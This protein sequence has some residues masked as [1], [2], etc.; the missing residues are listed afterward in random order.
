MSGIKIMV[1]D[2]HPMLLKGLTDELVQYGYNV[3][4]TA[5][6]GAAALETILE[7]APHIALLDIEMPIL[8]GFEVI[9][10]TL[11]KGLSTRFIILTSHKEKAFVHKAKKLNISGYLL[12][13]EP[14]SEIDKCIKAVAR[15]ETYFSKIFDDIFNSEISPQLEKIKFLSPSER[16]IVR[17]IAQ[18]KT[19]R[20]IGEMLS[21]SH[22]TVQKH[23]ANIIQKLDLPSE[24]DALNQWTLDNKEL[25]L[26]L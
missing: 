25:I 23:R 16:T 15:D 3:V 4:G 6:N 18:E 7:K 2:D 8:S 10:K 20:E 11:E 22:R 26:S 17:L 21:I 1:A 19:S 5:T 24:M 12:K 13:D 14:F 9:N